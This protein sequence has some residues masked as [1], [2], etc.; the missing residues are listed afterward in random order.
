MSKQDVFGQQVVVAFSADG[1]NYEELIA[2]KSFKDNKDDVVKTST[3]LGEAGKGLITVLDNG[4]TLSFEANI[5]DSKFEAWKQKLDDHR[6]GGNVAGQ[7]GQDPYMTVT[8]TL[9]YVDGSTSTKTFKGVKLHSDKEDDGG[10]QSESTLSFEA[11]YT[12]RVSVY[13]GGEANASASEAVTFFNAQFTAFNN[14]QADVNQ[15]TL[16]EYAMNPFTN[17]NNLTIG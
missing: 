5:K 7:R 4:G 1:K 2:V 14:M 15:K 16:E 12:E 3:V 11:E 17:L 9:T 8:R 6:R 10:S 13:N